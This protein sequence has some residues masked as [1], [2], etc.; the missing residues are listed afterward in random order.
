M[1]RRRFG[2]S[3][4]YLAF[5]VGVQ[6]AFGRWAAG[7]EVK[8]I[9]IPTAVCVAEGL[10]TKVDPATVALRKQQM[11]E[12]QS[13]LLTIGEGK[14]Q[15]VLKKQT[16]M[17]TVD[18]G[19]DV[20][21]IGAFKSKFW[22]IEEDFVD[23]VYLVK[24]KRKTGAIQKVLPCPG[25]DTTGN[26]GIGVSKKDLWLTNSLDD[27]IYQVK[28]RNGAVKNT[29]PLS[30]VEDI[31]HGGVVDAQ[32]H[33]WFGEWDY[34]GA[35]GGIKILELDPTVPEIARAW[36]ITNTETIYDLAF[37]K[38]GFLFVSVRTAADE[39]QIMKIDLGAST[40][41]DTYAKKPCEYGLAF[42]G[43][44]LMT[45]DWCAMKYYLYKVK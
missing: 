29:F 28:Q 20:A 31:L 40:I 10:S 3:V 26:N 4:S 32:G 23:S 39:R 22:G 14:G 11:A 15:L 8:L 38:Q 9:R 44:K 33:F 41:A 5:L 30:G 45:A 21:V 13:R 43:K 7:E 37:D 24:V 12:E 25:T 6:L 16:T 27:T 42:F 36:R 18:A 35:L 19:D 1:R 17:S 34:W 2:R